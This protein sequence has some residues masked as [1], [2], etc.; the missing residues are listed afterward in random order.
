MINGLVVKRE[1]ML[2]RFEILIP[3][4]IKMQMAGIKF[5]IKSMIMIG[6]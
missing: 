3:F 6:F 5:E 1:L 4:F 2:L